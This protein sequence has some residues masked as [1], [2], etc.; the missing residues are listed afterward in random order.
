MQLLKGDFLRGSCYIFNHR[1]NMIQ[2][3][4]LYLCVLWNWAI[5]AL[6]I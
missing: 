4:K 6:F 1:N 5:F 3:F 2:L